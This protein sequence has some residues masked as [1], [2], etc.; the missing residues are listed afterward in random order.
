MFELP[1]PPEAP[2][3]INAERKDG[4]LV[5]PVA[6]DSQTWAGILGFIFP[7]ATRS[8]DD[9]KTLQVVLRAA[10]KYG[11]DAVIKGAEGVLMLPK[12]LEEHPLG[13]YAI[14]CSYR[15]EA[16]ARSA[17]RRSLRKPLLG[18][19]GESSVELAGCLGAA[20]YR[21][22]AYYA[23]CGDKAVAALD[24]NEIHNLDSV[25]L[26][27]DTCSN[28]DEIIMPLFQRDY[29]VTQWWGAYARRLCHLLKERPCGD[30]VRDLSIASPFLKIARNC[31]YCEDRAEE[32]VIEFIQAYADLV[33]KAVSEVE[34]YMGKSEGPGR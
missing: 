30:T 31:S 22:F 3:T 28:E 2:A 19:V 27:C 24:E 12:F 34:L 33:D 16:A 29:P 23:Q 5:L 20:V 7:G 26:D 32:D 21:L 17:A 6:E 4:I 9:L 18:S 10:D 15:L 25:W 13:V 11:M 1:S 8:F 14:A